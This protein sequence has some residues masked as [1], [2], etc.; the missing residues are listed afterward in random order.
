[1]F[2]NRQKYVNDNFYDKDKLAK[3]LNMH[4][5]VGNSILD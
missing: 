2:T 4:D 3:Y 1:M 5:G